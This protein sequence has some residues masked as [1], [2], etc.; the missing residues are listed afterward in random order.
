M[1]KLGVEGWKVDVKGRLHRLKRVREVKKELHQVLNRLDATLR[2]LEHEF[3]IKGHIEEEVKA[4]ALRY[5]AYDE[6]PYCGHRK[7]SET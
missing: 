7:S 4:R 1:P 3:T 6:C 2:E 5:A